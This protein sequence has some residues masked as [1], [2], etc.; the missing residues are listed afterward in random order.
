M[1]KWWSKFF[2]KERP[3]PFQYGSVSTKR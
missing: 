1:E 3:A 2:E